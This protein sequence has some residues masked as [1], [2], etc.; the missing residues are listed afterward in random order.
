MISLRGLIPEE[1]WPMCAKCEIGIQ[2]FLADT[3]SGHYVLAA[4]CHGE[5]D[6]VVIPKE[7][8]F[9]TNPFSLDLGP[10]FGPNSKT[11]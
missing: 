4:V 3:V 7:A 6:L 11:W 5:I 2:D 9:A 1:N 10:A 8:W